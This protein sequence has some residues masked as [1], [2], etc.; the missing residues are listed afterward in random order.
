[1]KTAI[2]R[3]LAAAVGMLVIASCSSLVGPGEELVTA[4]MKWSQHHQS[5]YSMTI[6]RSCECT[7]QMTGPV[8]VI[9]ENGQVVS[10]KY[11]HTGEAVP[12]AYASWFTNVEGLFDRIAEIHAEDPDQIDVSYD[13]TLGYPTGIS[14]DFNKRMADDE[15]SLSVTD[16]SLLE[17][18]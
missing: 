10:R 11:T 12:A 17:H 13:A 15:F 4:R 5:S 3:G 9:V 2:V 8:R 14:V 7:P 1:M 16:F 6:L 18:N